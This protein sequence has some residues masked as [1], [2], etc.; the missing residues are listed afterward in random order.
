MALLQTSGGK[1]IIDFQEDCV[2]RFFPQRNIEPSS[3]HR[4][5]DTE[6]DESAV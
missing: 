1:V 2:C 4:P 6:Q 3:V 5:T